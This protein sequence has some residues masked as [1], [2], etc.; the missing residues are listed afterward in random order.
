MKALLGVL[1]ACLI[2]AC[3][4]E[5]S[6]PPASLE[7]VAEEGSE[8]A[9]PAEPFFEFHV[10]GHTI[11]FVETEGGGLV[12]SEIAPTDEASI[13]TG[14]DAEEALPSEIYQALIPGAGVPP[15][16]SEYEARMGAFVTERPTSVD[17]EVSARSGSPDIAIAPGSRLT[18]EA[19]GPH[20]AESHCPTTPDS[21]VQWS[22][23]EEHAP[24]TTRSFCWSAGF[25]GA[26]T[27]SSSSKATTQE[28]AAVV[29]DVCYNLSLPGW[30]G[31]WT[32]APGTTQR[33]W[34]RNGT[35]WDC[36]GICACGDLDIHQKTITGT[37]ST[38]APGC[39]AAGLTWRWGGGFWR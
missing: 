36:C 1:G 8:L 2:T 39:N 4:V 29:G 5:S 6:E 7:G 3:S 37:I 9:P 20:F 19:G 14:I 33:F 28:V 16:L 25:T 13:M 34:A 30:S 35:F 23:Y 38:G 11:Q 27:E 12:V 21:G 24:I 26:W 22:F 10:H 18:H 31:S 32:V 15:E 17:P